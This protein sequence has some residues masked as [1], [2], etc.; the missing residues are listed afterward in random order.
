MIQV[1]GVLTRVRRV[2][3]DDSGVRWSD[4]ELL[5]WL[6]DGQREVVMLAPQA[7]STTATMTLSAG[8]RQTIPADGMQFLRLTRNIG[9][10]SI[11]ETQKALLDSQVPTWY[12][13]E[14]E[15]V[16]HYVADPLEPRS[17]HVYPQGEKPVEI[18]YV[19]TPEESDVAG[20]LNIPAIYANALVDYILYRAYSKDAE[21]TANRELAMMHYSRFNE[22][23][24]LRGQAEG[25]A[26]ISQRGVTKPM[27]GVN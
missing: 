5:D 27:Q 18:V 17:F 1:N 11:R 19:K 20:P 9:G 24:G 23:L 7:G 6:N 16:I 14:G 4:P 12:D 13:A 21:E 10:R 8:S 25:T 3:Q 26:F 15:D 2:L 22:G